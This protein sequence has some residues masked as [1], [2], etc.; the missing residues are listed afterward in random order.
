MV[1]LSVRWWCA[2]RCAGDKGGA[3][4]P[5]DEGF[6]ISVDA[7]HF[8]WGCSGGPDRGEEVGFNPRPIPSRPQSQEGRRRGSWSLSELGDRANRDSSQW[9]SER[10]EGRAR[11]QDHR[12]LSGGQSQ[13]VGGDT[14]IRLEGRGESGGV[15]TR[16]G[17]RE[18][19]G[20]EELSGLKASGDRPPTG[21][22]GS[23][24]PAGFERYPP[25]PGVRIG[26][27]SHLL[28]ER[29]VSRTCR[30]RGRPGRGG[31]RG[32]RGSRPAPGC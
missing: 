21:A 25:D 31:R 7:G 1:R 30:P 14:W 10:A 12:E 3:G 23:R 22:D 27:R 5:N 6:M 4:D 2:S 32:G 20:G 26:G 15:W 18:E 9:G 17:P 13:N 11:R 28:W 29:R 24:S 19:E 16:E 8:V